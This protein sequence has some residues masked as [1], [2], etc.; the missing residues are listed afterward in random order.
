MTWTHLRVFAVGFYMGMVVLSV[1]ILA[2]IDR[3]RGGRK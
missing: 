1:M 3:D 2:R